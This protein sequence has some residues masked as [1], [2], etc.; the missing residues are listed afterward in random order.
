MTQES[1][2]RAAYWSVLDG[3]AALREK[4]N[5]DSSHGDHSEK[6]FRAYEKLAECQLIGKDDLEATR[7]S[8]T[9]AGN[10]LIQFLERRSTDDERYCCIS[11]FTVCHGLFLLMSAGQFQLSVRLSRLVQSHPYYWRCRDLFYDQFLVILA[12]LI[13][14]DDQRVE[15]ALADFRNTVRTKKECVGHYTSVS[16][17][18]RNAPKELDNG[19]HQL[20]VWEKRNRR[21]REYEPGGDVSWESLGLYNLAA[22]RGL[23]VDLAFDSDLIPVGLLVTDCQ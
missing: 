12:A 21:N 18:L 5:D 9:N 7:E 16:A 3:I 11:T 6:L 20:D 10:V 14:R 17:I 8:L 22:H 13:L 2:Y 4:I 23:S 19:L 1:N 15:E